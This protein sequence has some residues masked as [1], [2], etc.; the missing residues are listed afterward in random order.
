MLPDASLAARATEWTYFTEPSGISNRYSWSKSFPVLDASSMVFCTAARSSGWVRWTINSIVGFVFGH[1]GKFGNFRRTRR[2]LHWRL[3][4][5]S[6]RYGS[7]SALRS[8]KFR[9]ATARLQS[10]FDRQSL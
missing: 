7:T 3:S 1:L 8:N 10:A 6:S 4:M 9:Y 2:F 5:Q